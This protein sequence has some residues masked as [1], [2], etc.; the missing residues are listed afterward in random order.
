MTCSLNEVTPS[1]SSQNDDSFSKLDL[2]VIDPL[3][4]IDFANRVRFLKCMYTYYVVLYYVI[5]SDMYYA[6]LYYVHCTIMTYVNANK[7][8][9]YFLRGLS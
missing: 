9:F 2:S 7:A 5:V 8:S 3:S 1:W 4:E 6:N